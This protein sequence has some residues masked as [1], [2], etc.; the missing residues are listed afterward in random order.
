[1]QFRALSILELCYTQ[2]LYGHFF[3]IA[4]F[5]SAKLTLTLSTTSITLQQKINWIRLE[6]RGAL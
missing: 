4:D 3:D 5:F 1:M 6:V 2:L